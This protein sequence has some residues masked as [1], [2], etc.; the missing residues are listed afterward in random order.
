GVPHD[1]LGRALAQPDPEVERWIPLKRVL[2]EKLAALST[3]ALESHEIIARQV[4]ET[5]LEPAERRKAIEKYAY[6][7]AGREALDLLSNTDGDRGR[8]TEAMRGWSQALEV[9]PGVETVARLAFAH[10]L[11]KDSVALVTLRSQA[12]ARGI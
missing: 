11:R 8:M 10:A 12:E 6:T 9:R 5:V 1:T 4:L 7:R 2:A 3:A